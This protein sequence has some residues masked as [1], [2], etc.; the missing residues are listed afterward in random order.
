MDKSTPQWQTPKTHQKLAPLA[1]LERQVESRGVGSARSYDSGNPSSPAIAH[2]RPYVL[3]SPPETDI[4]DFNEKEYV[5][6]LVSAAVVNRQPLLPLTDTAMNPSGALPAAVGVVAT[7]FAEPLL[8]YKNSGSNMIPGGVAIKPD[9]AIDLPDP[10]YISG[11]PA[12]AAASGG[13]G[14][15]SAISGGGR[16]LRHETG[17]TINNI[18]AAKRAGMNSSQSSISFSAKNPESSRTPFNAT[19]IGYS[20]FSEQGGGSGRNNPMALHSQP[21]GLT[22]HILNTTGT[23][24]TY[25]MPAENDR[26]DGIKQAMRSLDMPAV[27][28]SIE[29]FQNTPSSIY[30][31]RRGFISQDPTPDA[32]Q[33][34]LN[35][36]R[37]T[38]LVNPIT[39]PAPLLTNLGN[40]VSFLDHQSIITCDIRHRDKSLCKPPGATMSHRGRRVLGMGTGENSHD[41]SLP[42]FDE[43]PILQSNSAGIRGTRLNEG[44]SHNYFKKSVLKNQDI[45]DQMFPVI[46]PTVDNEAVAIK[47]MQ[48]YNPRWPRKSFR[49]QLPILTPDNIK[50]FLFHF[51]RIGDLDAL[52]ILCKSP[53][54]DLESS[55]D[56]G[57]TALI[58]AAIGGHVQCI[59]LLT[60]HRAFINRQDHSGRTALHWAA[61]HGFVAVVK[62]LCDSH[63]DMSQEDYQGKLPIHCATYPETVEA[64]EYLVRSALPAFRRTTMISLTSI[65]ANQRRKTMSG[66]VSPEDNSGLCNAM[67]LE[68]MTPLMWAAYHGHDRHIETLLSHGRASAFLQDIEG[69]TAKFP[70]LI[71]IP[72]KMGRLP[73]H[74]G[75]GEGNIAVVDMIMLAPGSNWNAFDGLKRTPLHWAA[76]RGQPA[77]INLLCQRGANFNLLD[78]FGAS[79]LCYAIQHRNMDCVHVLLRK[80]IWVDSTDTSG[81]T[82]LMWASLQGNLDVIKMLLKGNAKVAA[83]AK[84]GMTALH[85]AAY[86]GHTTCCTHLLRAGSTIDSKDLL[87]QTALLK[88]TIM[89]SG[90]AVIL[91]SNEGS[92]PDE[93]DNQKRTAVHWAAADGSTNV[94]QLLLS[95]GASVDLQDVNGYTPLA[96]AAIAGY[97]EAVVMLLNHDADDLKRD[98]TGL[99]AL[100]LA[101]SKGHTAICKVLKTPHTINM[102]SNADILKA[103]TPLDYAIE[104]KSRECIAMFKESAAKTAKDIARYSATKIQKAWKSS[105]T[106]CNQRRQHRNEQALPIS[107]ELYHQCP[108]V[109]ISAL[110]IQRWYR[111]HSQRRKYQRAIKIHRMA[112]LQAQELQRAEKAQHQAILLHQQAMVEKARA[113][114]IYQQA[115]NHRKETELKYNSYVEKMAVKQMEIEKQLKEM[116]EIQVMQQEQLAKMREETQGFTSRFSWNKKT[117]PLGLQ[118]VTESSDGVVASN[119]ILSSKDFARQISSTTRYV[120]HCDDSMISTGRNLAVD[121]LSQ[122]QSSHATAR[123]SVESLTLSTRQKMGNEPRHASNHILHDSLG[124]KPSLHLDITAYSTATTQQELQ[125]VLTDSERTAVVRDKDISNPLMAVFQTSTHFDVTSTG[126]CV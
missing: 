57:R 103:K 15:G 87:G 37:T 121:K 90:N 91:L 77:C 80:G 17:N 49:Y 68:L 72:D 20:D 18:I 54:V 29:P 38:P 78:E 11:P 69:K 119:Q 62:E 86:G 66:L 47:L 76:V 107:T 8:V 98:H 120:T 102:P 108:K 43:Y 114:N 109:R 122:S 56:A 96:E 63:A 94:L 46:V 59:R 75:C 70:A 22:N 50:M 81:R 64:L 105:Q 21:H 5:E 3:R 126:T 110:C 10:R 42:Q 85:Y 125:S 39:T 99:I 93:V 41:I 95:R 113:E 4:E 26:I 2:K 79:A 45:F 19:G 53:M 74:Y 124:N 16:Q 67:D 106:R 23:A 88:A 60:T 44:R 13:G 6:P 25:T 1:K 89:G 117:V 123:D 84:S 83:K 73:L 100:H 65:T 30:S 92:N 118:T 40:G 33:Y 61:Y 12:S 115:E 27:V 58:F 116:E 101:A 14:G 24:M 28:S 97:T 112:A 35:D 55:D 32:P 51:A 82:P 104:S 48:I 36:C 31:D 9:S 71:N 7:H 52:K 111:C 34:L